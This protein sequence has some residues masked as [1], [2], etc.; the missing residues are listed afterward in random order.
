M[1]QVLLYLKMVFDPKGKWVLHLEKGSDPLYPL[2]VVED[3]WVT[4]EE[5]L[6][7]L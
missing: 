7:D 2:Y 6:V 5:C 4:D 1:M 3:P